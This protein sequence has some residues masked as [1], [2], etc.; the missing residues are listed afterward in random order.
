[1]PQR[2]STIGKRAGQ[3]HGG[4]IYYSQEFKQLV[5]ANPRMLS[6]IRDIIETQLQSLKAGSVAPWPPKASPK[7]T[8]LKSQRGQRGGQMHTLPLMVHFGDKR[9]FVKRLDFERLQTRLSISKK[10][11][12]AFMRREHKQRVE[13]N[14]EVSEFFKRQ[15]NKLGPFNVKVSPYH[16]IYGKYVVSD[17][18][19]SKSKSVADMWADPESPE[20]FAIA[21]K[22]SAELGK[23][24]KTLGDPEGRKYDLT[25]QNTFYDKETKTIT[26]VDTFNDRI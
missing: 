1:M 2:K 7:L 14:R 3:I 20:E 25:V 18:I 4:R 23:A 19:S 17:F 15:Q 16:L 22:I 9:F 21:T 10:E 6:Q 12:A 26:L 11:L 5:S 24:R 8:I 13:V